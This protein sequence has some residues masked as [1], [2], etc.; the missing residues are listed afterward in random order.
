MKKQHGMTMTGFLMVAIVAGFAALTL[1]KLVPTYIEYRSIKQ[2]MDAAVS[3]SSGAKEATI[4]D[5]KESL[6]KRLSMNYVSS[7]KASD[8]KVVAAGQGFKATVDYQAEKPYV[9]NVFLVVKFHYET[10]TK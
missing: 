1:M 10:E 5:I 3:Q 7:V 9:A 6:G 4:G 2:A 8:I